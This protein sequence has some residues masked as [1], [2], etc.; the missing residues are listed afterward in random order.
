MNQ[1]STEALDQAFTALAIYNTGSGRGSLLPI[2]KAVAANLPGNLETR[3]LAVL[4]KSP[5]DP[6][7]DYIYSKLALI[8]TAKSLAVLAKAA[9]SEVPSATAARTALENFPAPEATRALQQFLPKASPGDAVALLNSL[10][11]RRDSEAVPSIA[12]FLTADETNPAVLEAA[13]AALGQIASSKAAKALKQF[14]S[15]TPQALRS[16]VADSILVCADGLLGRG[17]R[18][19][20]RDLYALLTDSTQPVHVREA[21]ARGLKACS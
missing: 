8:G 7:C 6:A 4:D 13:I 18:N 17:Q 12:K 16:T 10:G 11:V 19:Q 2:D 14:H 3:L 5:A 15:R 9:A 21:A 1:P 20:A